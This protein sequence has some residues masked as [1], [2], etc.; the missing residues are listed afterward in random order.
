IYVSPQCQVATA[1]ECEEHKDFVPGHSL[2]GEGIDITT[3]EKRGGKVLDMNQWQKPDG[4]C[5]LCQNQL[6]P[7]KPLQRLPLAAVDW[8]VKTMCQQKVHT[9]LQNNGFG[10]VS[11]AGSDVQN[12]WKLGLDIQV[13][14]QTNIQVALAASHSKTA[15]FSMDKASQDKYSFARHEVSCTYYS[16]R[17]DHHQQLS[18]H[19]KLALHNLPGK[20]HHATQLE[21]RQ[22]IATYGTHFITRL[23]LGGRIR[24]VTAVRECELVL[25]GVTADEVKDCLRI[26]AAASIG[27]AVKM[28]AAYKTCEE[29]KKKQTFQGSFHQVYRERHTEVVGGT[30]HIDLLFPDNHNPE[31]FS[32]WLEGVISVPGLLSYSLDPIHT[33]VPEGNPRREGLQ[34]AVREYVTER[35]LWRNC[36][37]P[38]PPGTQRSVRDPC[39]CVCPSDGTTSS[40]CC[41]RKRG[42]GKLT[43]KIQRAHGL[44]GDSFSRTD[45]YVMVFYQG[46][47]IRTPTVWNNDNPVWN[48]HLDLGHIQ[49][50]GENSKLQIQVWDEDNKYDDD[51]LGLCEKTLEAGKLHNEVCYLDHGRLDFQ[52]H[53]ICAPY[54][55]GPFCFDYVPQ[56]PKSGEVLLRKGKAVTVK[57]KA[58]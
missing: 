38:C 50:L 47:E 48:I 37:Q 3:L 34:Q 16:F 2:A 44:W 1:E 32:E 20:Y 53:L 25:N 46:R 56:M 18:K 10:V 58:P 51:S 19:F 27:G 36:T 52:Y 54:L 13:K 24:D 5:T 57:Q 11:A 35:A 17:T 6:L 31:T 12:D 8:E 42:L 4:T 9:S 41:S 43:V 30:S 15:D 7:D 29:L 40:M 28:D 55:G 23:H 49:I 33:L 26:E 21:Y 14:P 45:A 39:S 22:L